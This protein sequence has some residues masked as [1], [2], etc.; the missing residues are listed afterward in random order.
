MNKKIL[1][2]A[3]TAAPLLAGAAQRVWHLPM[4]VAEG[5]LNVSGSAD[6]LEIFGRH[7]PETMPGAAGNALRFDGYSTYAQGDNLSIPTNPGAMSFSV[8]VAPET[9]PVIKIDQATDEKMRLAGTLDENL[10]QGW[11]FNLGYTGKYSFEC[12]SGGWKVTVEASDLLPCYEWSRLT[13]TVDGAAR[14]VILYRNGVEVGRGKCMT[15]IDNGARLL[16]VGKSPEGDS[17]G[18]FLI[19]TFNGL[20]DDIEIFDGVLTA[21]EI[22]SA[23]PENE[24]MLS[25]SPSR[26][27]GNLLRPLFHGM[28]SAN[29]TN[30][31][32]G[33][34][35]SDG[36]YHLFFQKNANG[37]YMT[38]LHWGHISS[39][40]LYDWREEP[41]AIAPGE[42]YDIKGCWSGCVFT[43]DEITGGK[44]GAIYTGVDYAKAVMALAVSGDEALVDWEKRGVL[45]NGRPSGLSDDFRD[46]YFFRN[47][48]KAYIIVGSSKNGIGTTTLHEYDPTYGTWSN[49]GRTFF[50]GTNAALHG[51]FWEMPNVTR[52]ENGKWLFTVTP[53]GT[54][55]GVHTLYWVGDIAADG[56]FV[57]DASQIWPRE[58]ELMSKD[59]YGLLSPTIYQHEGKTIALGIVPDKVSTESNC[60]WGW[61]HNYSFPREWSLDDNG[62]L[63]QKPYSGLTSLRSASTSWTSAAF[64]LDSN[65]N[66]DPVKGRR[67]EIL[68]KFTLGSSA[69]GFNFLKGS[70]GQASLTYTPSSN[71]LTVD[72][73][74]LRRLVND[75]HSYDGLYTCRLPQRPAAGEEMTLQLFLDGSILDI[76]VNDRWATS[77]R[78]F[79]TGD[80]TGDVEVFSRGGTT[81]VNSLSAWVLESDGSGSGVEGI[82]A[83]AAAQTVNV[84]TPDGQLLRTAVSAPDALTGLPAGIYLVGDRKVIVR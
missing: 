82:G 5:H 71:E 44:P 47:G 42:P 32:H 63:R 21:A 23:R 56:T 51:T 53:L 45:V 31:C 17:A 37:P 65:L 81:R 43:D 49:D 3:L 52:M 70:S 78:L 35:W 75:G 58:V 27:E 7:N 28:P 30:E 11:S 24:P 9:Y 20:I 54:S 64:D 68:G 13:A 66:L 74:G 19:N 14:T 55:A 73:T 57:P 1:L 2:L 39:E 61:A 12:Y 16:T 22:A 76:F 69:F 67:L 40:N 18:P 83:D 36:R 15:T 8:W 80:E 59:G 26:Y 72:L 34:T 77:I 38:R 10:R 29:W 84:C 62:E 4:D 6:A 25:V 79:P 50:S 48:D 41:I 60:A 46:P 33:M